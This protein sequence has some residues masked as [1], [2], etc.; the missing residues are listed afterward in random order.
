MSSR[1]LHRWFFSRFE[2]RVIRGFFLL[3]AMLLTSGC[4]SLAYYGQAIDGQLR[5]MAASQPIEEL[6]ADDATDAVLRARLHQVP[7]LR[8]FAVEELGLV[9]SDSYAS[10]ADVQREAMVWSLVAAP[11]DSLEP[12]TWCYPVIGCAAYRGYFAKADAEAHAARLA[13]EGWDV[14]VEP[15]PAYSTLGWFND[16]LPSTVLHWPMTDIA[17]LIFHEL[18]HETLYADGDSAFNEGY[19]TLLE[20]EGVR[21]WLLRHGTEEQQRAR[22]LREE[23][24][25]AFIVLL[26]QT[27]ERLA[28]VYAAESSRDRMLHQKQAILLQLQADYRQLKDGWG[29]YAG[30]DRWFARPLNNAHLA[31]VA[32]YHS[33]VPAFRQLLHHLDGDMPAF[34][35]ACRELAELPRLA[36]D[37]YL[38]SLNPIDKTAEPMLNAG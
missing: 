26:R 13:D 28:V 25:A 37:A 9:S 24:R 2:Q 6:L 7:A 16:P 36:R 23:R 31:S 38:G 35:A 11:A 19:A 20:Q 8:D 18:S 27:R 32:T 10:Y 21:R 15:V 30:Y 17:G 3:S 34:H 33:L 4:A 1:V 12:H 29:G 5:V 14:A 22:D